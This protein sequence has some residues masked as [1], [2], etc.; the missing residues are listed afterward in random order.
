MP[1]YYWVVETKFNISSYSISNVSLFSMEE[2]SLQKRGPVYPEDKVSS[3]RSSRCTGAL[4][5]SGVLLNWNSCHSQSPPAKDE[6]CLLGR[7]NW[8]YRTKSNHFFSLVCCRSGC[9][10]SEKDENKSSQLSKKE[11]ENVYCYEGMERVR[12]LL[13]HF[14]T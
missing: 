9:L 10:C 2:I 11:D 8:K 4:L 1:Y 7:T 14:S 13:C 5:Y 6:A 3:L 12:L